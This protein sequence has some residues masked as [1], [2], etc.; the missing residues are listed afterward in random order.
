M[1]QDVL[2]S[3]NDYSTLRIESREALWRL[4]IPSNPGLTN[5]NIINSLA[6]ALGVEAEL[7]DDMEYSEF[8]VKCSETV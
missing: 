8:S 6:N 2:L 3:D 1:A 7:T 4:G 5:G